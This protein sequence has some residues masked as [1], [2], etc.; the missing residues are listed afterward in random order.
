MEEVKTNKHVLGYSVIGMALIVSLLFNL[1]QT[2]TPKE[3]IAPIPTAEIIVETPTPVQLT[4]T[5]T[6]SMKQLLDFWNTKHPASASANPQT[7]PKVTTTT[8]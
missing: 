2:N 4:P 1:R 6:P 8:K 3:P 5:P 7:L